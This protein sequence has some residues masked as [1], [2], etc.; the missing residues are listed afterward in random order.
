MKIALISDLH[1]EFK[2]QH[3][4]QLDQD[5][6]V[7][8]LAGDIDNCKKAIQRGLEIADGHAR[9]IVQVAGNHEFYGERLDK[10][11]KR[12]RDDADAW[13]VAG[14]DSTE[15]HFLQNDMVI[16]DNVKFLGGT[17]WTDYQLYGRASEDMY[18]AESYMN[19]HRRIKFKQGE[20]TYRRFLPKDALEEHILTRQFIAREKS[21]PF[22]GK[23]VVVTHHAPS[24]LSIHS[25]Y[26]DPS[27]L[28]SAYATNLEH[29]FHDVDYWF[30]GHMHDPSDYTLYGCNVIANPHG[31]PGERDDPQIRYIEC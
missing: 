12:L 24:A 4:P 11:Y 3:V 29:Y 19:D 1:A 18:R 13:G 20:A 21:L 2:S 8:V 15:V 9:H 23:R 28:N 16:I 25:K 10:G 27:E 30:H 7:L 6:D 22:K 26:A 17:L 31:Y 5:V 14:S